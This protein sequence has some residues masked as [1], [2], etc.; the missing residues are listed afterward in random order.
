VGNGNPIVQQRTRWLRLR[1]HAS[2]IAHRW[3]LLSQVVMSIVEIAAQ[4][5][6]SAPQIDSSGRLR[7]VVIAVDADASRVAGLSDAQL[8]RAVGLLLHSRAIVVAVSHHEP[9]HPAVVDA[10][11][12]YL[13]TRQGRGSDAVIVNDLE[14]EVL[15][16]QAAASTHPTAALTLAWLLRA[17]ERVP[18]RDALAL[19]S[20]A[21]SMLLSGPDF[22][23]WL[24]ARGPAR[25]ADSPHRIDLARDGNTLAIRLDRSHRRNAIDSAMRDALLD[26]LRVAQLD[27]TV[28]VHLSGAGPSFCAGGD[29]DEFGSADDLTTAHVVRVTS[30]LGAAIHSISE[31]VTARV[32]GACFGAG[33]ELPAFAARVVAAAGTEFA[34]PELTMGLIPGA[35]GTVSLPRRIGRHRT[36]W[37]ALTA[38]R[39]SVDRALEW[40][41]VDA[42]E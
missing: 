2:T 9:A 17:S 18:V 38:T 20:A 21:Y 26:A 22:R 28:R 8:A 15:R 36:F 42:L 16:V 34:L 31:R 12:V 33:V 7:Q 27:S 24:L 35:G 5:E 19:E 11:D 41:L 4:L 37:L 39:V 1:R 30:S 40:G 29:L 32:H 25:P 6:S 13:S 14:A 23:S 3:Q 10:A